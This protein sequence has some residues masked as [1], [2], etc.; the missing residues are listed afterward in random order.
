M[1]DPTFP[2]P[3]R[4]SYLLVGIVAIA[5][6]AAAVFLTSHLFPATK[7]D[8]SHVRT[9]ILPTHTVY[10]SNS[11]VVGPAQTDDTFFLAETVSVSN[12]LRMPVST[13]DVTLTLVD[14][15][16]RQLT[17]K[18]FEKSDLTNLELTFPALTPLLQT[19][20][21]RDTIIPPGQS[22]TGTVLFALQ[23]PRTLYDHRKTATV[24]L[25]FYH[26]LSVYETVP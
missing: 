1:S 11:I 3:E 22:R 2:Q 25:D 17:T 19:P 18:A 5:A 14:P 10:K 16:G 7:V 12:G 15:Q 26:Q 20:L 8:V 24:K 6:V 23:V 4:R 21:Y 13:D 9:A